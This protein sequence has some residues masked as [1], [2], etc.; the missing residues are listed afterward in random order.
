MTWYNICFKNSILATALKIDCRE[1]S[2]QAVVV[3]QARDDGTLSQDGGDGGGQKYPILE[4][5]MDWAVWYE[6]K[7]KR[8]I[9]NLLA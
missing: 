4:P 8:V 2:R 7:K 9:L 3:I 5:L 1:R 6:R